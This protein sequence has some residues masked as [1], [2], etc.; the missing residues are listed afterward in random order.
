MLRHNLFI[1][2]F[3]V[4]V[5]LL[6]SFPLSANNSR[7]PFDIYMIVWRGCEDACKGFQDY[8]RERDIDVNFTLSNA[9]RDKKRLLNSARSTRMSI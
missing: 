7:K 9:A 3:L 2:V 4:G 1:I 8:F 5:S 6:I